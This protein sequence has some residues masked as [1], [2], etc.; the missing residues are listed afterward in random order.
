MSGEP[1]FPS[2]LRILPQRVILCTQHG[3]CYTKGTLERHL[4]RKHNLKGDPKKL[5]LEKLEQVHIA[6]D[7]NRSNSR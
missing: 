1:S 3:S 7:V 4:V 5:M 2:Y 6:A